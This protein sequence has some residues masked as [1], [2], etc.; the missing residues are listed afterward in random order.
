MCCVTVFRNCRV[1]LGHWDARVLCSCSV[2]CMAEGWNHGVW[3]CGSGM[4]VMCHY[5]GVCVC[6][7]VCGLVGSG[8][9]SLSWGYCSG[10]VSHSCKCDLAVLGD[11]GI[12]MLVWGGDML[13]VTRCMG[14]LGGCD[15]HGARFMSP[16]LSSQS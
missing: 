14:L 10:H 15:L 8:V 13:C 11:L 16:R 4:H 3:C 9:I 12:M 6:V 2:C 7:Y 1:K 5:G